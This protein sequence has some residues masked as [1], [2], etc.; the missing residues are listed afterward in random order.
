MRQL[1]QELARD[2]LDEEQGFLLER[3]F[4]IPYS[5]DEASIDAEITADGQPADDAEIAELK[6]QILKHMI[7]TL[8]QGRKG[9]R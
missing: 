3:I 2:Y 5:A 9:T 6:R 4:E 7:Q 8:L 1:I